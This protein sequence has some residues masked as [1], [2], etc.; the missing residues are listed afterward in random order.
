MTGIVFCIAAFILCFIATRRSLPTGLGVLMT[1]GYFYG[2]L[3]ANVPNQSMHFLFDVGAIGFYAALMT[4]GLKPDERP[5]A[6]TLLPWMALLIGWPILLFLFPVQDPLIQLVG[7]RA[8]ILFVPFVMIGAMLD[9]DDWYALARWIAVLNLVAFGFAVGEYFLGVPRFYPYNGMTQIIYASTD[10]VGHEYRIPATFI[11]AAPYCAMMVAS[12]PLLLGATVQRRGGKLD[13]WL[14]SAA[15]L[16]SGLG[17]FMGAS[18]SSA[19]VLILMLGLTFLMRNMSPKVLLRLAIAIACVGWTV[20]DNPRLQRF[21]TLSDTN[22]VEERIGTSVNT[23]FIDAAIKYPMGNG[24]GGGG[25]SIPYFLQDRTI[26]PVAIENEYGRI[27]LE[28][29]IPGLLIWIAFIGW[30]LIRPPPRKNDPW[31]MALR[32]SRIYVAISFAT[33]VTGSGTLNSVPGTAF[34]LMLVGWLCTAR[35]APA[36]QKVARP[37][38]ITK[39]RLAGNMM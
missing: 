1:V 39:R 21:T 11:H 38:R 37:D 28:I 8:Q 18:R 5:V 32:L 30:I 2:I 31:R 13:F 36:G 19:A 34:L 25:T 9:A 20:A 27:L 14:L 15:I 24:L 26:S 17:V 6:E 4:R 10:V 16:A 3:R 29:G 12:T 35:L 7:L 22:Y 33:A 23:T